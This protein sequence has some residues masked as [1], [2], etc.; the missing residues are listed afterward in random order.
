[1][2]NCGYGPLAHAFPCFP[3]KVDFTVRSTINSAIRQ[4]KS[5]PWQQLKEAATKDRGPTQVASGGER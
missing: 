1:M 2:A 5:I 4:V 3:G